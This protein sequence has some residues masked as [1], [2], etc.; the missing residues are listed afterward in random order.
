MPKQKNKTI[1]KKEHQKKLLSKIISTFLLVGLI[2][3]TGYAIFAIVR[4]SSKA[5]G[6]TPTITPSAQIV[7]TSAPISLSFVSTA[8]LNTG[9]T[10]TFTYQSGYAGTLTT[11]NTTINS[12]A[13]SSVTINTPSGYISNVLTVA[14]N[15]SSGSTVT[16]STTALTSP[17]T[18]ANYAFSVQTSTGDYGANFQY[19]GQANVVQVTGFIPITLSFVIRTV[20]D[21]ANT[22]VCDLGTATTTSV[23]SCQYR[24]KVTTNA[25][26]GY[27]ISMQA[28]GGLTNG[29]DILTNAAPGFGG[30]GG[31][32]IL[33]G[34]ESYGVVVTP[35][36][37]TTSGGNAFAANLFDAGLVNS[38]RYDYNVSTL[39]L[40]ANKPNNPAAFGATTNTTLITH[41]LAIT[42]GSPSGNFTQTITY[43]VSPSF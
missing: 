18:A 6:L 32:N 30:T 13:P 33:P 11:A 23:S 35:G 25:K 37:L 28:S 20:A 40:T 7:S 9:S 36:N 3:Y 15:I 39:L 34:S 24:L 4:E 38:V 8:N 31:T 14:S 22:N 26:N 27:T 5:S 21:S 42:P 19:V 16:I 1:T 10:I 43:T 41:N 12:I 29:S 2:L 17:S